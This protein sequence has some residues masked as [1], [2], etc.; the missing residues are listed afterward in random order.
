MWLKRKKN[1]EVYVMSRHKALEYCRSKHRRDSVI[2]SIS[3]P[4]MAYDDAPFCSAENRVREILPLCFCDA[5]GPG[6]DVYG[7]DVEESDLMTDE[8]A[9]KTA[10]FVRANRDKRIIVHCD[11][12][13]SR[14][15]GVAAAI[16]K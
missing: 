11:A 10:R 12:G 9:I 14:S 16:V 2:V 8:D 13:I 6:K 1:I 4:H 5:E 15:A 7:L 3:D